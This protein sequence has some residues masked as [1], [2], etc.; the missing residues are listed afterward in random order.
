MTGRLQIGE[1]AEATGLS[2]RTIR[3]YEEVA[4]IPAP[5]RSP[6]GFRLY[7]DAA[8][9]RLLAIRAMKPLQLSLEQMRELLDALDALAISPSAE[10]RDVVRGYADLVAVRRDRLRA[11]LTE[12]EAFHTALT[13]R[14]TVRV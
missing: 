6:G 9:A 14:I 13:D 12:T 11:T 7:T 2:L 10:L 8:V 1:V 3:Y 5:E 4:L